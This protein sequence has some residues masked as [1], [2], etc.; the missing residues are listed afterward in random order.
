MT[1]TDT[2][3]VTRTE[4]IRLRVT[5]QELEA[6]RQ[7]ALEDDRSLSSVLRLALRDLIA[8]RT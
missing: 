8:K 5:P 1:G 4:M 7:V 2:T 6:L 3:K